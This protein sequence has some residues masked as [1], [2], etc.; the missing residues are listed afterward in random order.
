MLCT[1][2]YEHA[3]EHI[4][5]GKLRIIAHHACVIYAMEQYQVKTAEDALRRRDEE[6]MIL[7]AK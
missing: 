5:A 4:T 6:D 3:P 1:F 7:Y 2:C